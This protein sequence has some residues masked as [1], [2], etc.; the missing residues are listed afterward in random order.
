MP[1][2]RQHEARARTAAD[3]KLQEEEAFLEARGWRRKRVGAMSRW[4]KAAG[5]TMFRWEAMALEKMIE[6]PPSP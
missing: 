6:A 5:P 4:Y 3:V 1:R 2:T